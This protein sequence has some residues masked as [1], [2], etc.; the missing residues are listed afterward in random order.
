MDQIILEDVKRGKVDLKRKDFEDKKVLVTGGA[1]FLGSWL[2]DI[3]VTLDAEV[4]CLDN[5]STGKLAN[6]DHLLENS[7]FKFLNEDVC[8]FKHDKKY[9]LILHFASRASPE[10]YQQHPIETLKVNSLGSHNML[11]LARKHDST[12]LFASTSEVYGDAEVFPTPESYLGRVNPIGPRSCYYEGKRFSEALFTAYHRKHELNMKIARIFNSYGPRLRAEGGYGRAVSRFITQAL[13]N[14]PVT[15][16]GD[17]LQTRSFC[18]VTDTC[19][20]LL[21]LLINEETNGEVVNVGN[22]EEI[23]ILELAQKIKQLTESI[24]HITFH[25]L[26]EDDPRRR[27]PDVG[28]AEKILGW[29]PKIN[30]EEGLTKTIKWFKRKKAQIE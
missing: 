26:P 22:K 14:Q 24:S 1:G 13:T 23:T 27:W 3:L 2:C 15:V 17:G 16:Y 21:V 9:D 4:D 28:K 18:Y 5:L 8:T 7:K 20:G 25:P 19:I 11:E 10:E 30:L 6:I 12:I 29:K